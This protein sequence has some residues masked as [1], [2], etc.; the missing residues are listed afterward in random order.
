MVHSASYA[1]ANAGINKAVQKPNRTLPEIQ[2]SI[3]SPAFLAFSVTGQVHQC[4]PH[5]TREAKFYVIGIRMHVRRRGFALHIIIIYSHIDTSLCILSLIYIYV[6][7]E[8][9]RTAN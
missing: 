7:K 1:C 4:F 2:A 3:M 8:I 9:E 6:E 5:Y